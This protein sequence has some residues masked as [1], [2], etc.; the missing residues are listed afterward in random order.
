[1]KDSISNNIDK[2]NSVFNNFLD[3]AS[4]ENILNRCFEEGERAS[5][6]EMSGKLVPGDHL[7]ITYG[8]L[9]HH[10]IYSG[11]GKVVHYKKG[12]GKGI[13]EV[14][15]QEFA[16]DV[17]SRG[18]ISKKIYIRKH[19]T[20]KFSREESVERARS[21]IGEAGWNL[22]LNNCE[23]FVEWCVNGKFGPEETET[24]QTPPQQSSAPTLREKFEYIINNECL[25]EKLFASA[26]K[27]NLSVK[28]LGG[29][30]FWNDVCG[31]SGWKLQQNKLTGHCRIIDPQNTRRMWG[32]EKDIVK[33]IN[34]LY[35]KDVV[36]GYLN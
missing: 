27:A 15:I 32:A 5:L 31:S 16:E 2:L 6:L 3:A 35:D 26:G 4:I 36:R 19:E 13:I 14:P 10:G 23:H 33:A 12:K 28:T 7:Y 17:P 9:T 29:K 8:I 11:D 20:R 30:T 24:P 18:L 1:M 25:R 34:E 22:L 21:R